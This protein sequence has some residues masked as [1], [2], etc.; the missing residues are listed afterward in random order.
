MLPRMLDQAQENRD[1]GTICNNYRIDLATMTL[2]LKNVEL[3]DE[4]IASKQKPID[5]Y[6]A[7][8]KTTKEDSEMVLV[9]LHDGK[10]Q[11]A[12]KAK[13][14]EVNKKKELKRDANKGYSDAIKSYEKGKCTRVH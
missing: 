6:S 11:A 2:A 7:L 3:M 1:N 4:I 10:L 13:Q 9:R 5:K 8:V 12:L 14:K